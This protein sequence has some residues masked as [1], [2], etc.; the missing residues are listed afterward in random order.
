[1]H[2]IYEAT[3]IIK[4]TKL[5]NIED[6]KEEKA[7]VIKGDNKYLPGI[8]IYKGKASIHIWYNNCPHANLTLD[9]IEGKVQ[10]K[11]NDLLCANHGAKFNPETGECIKGPCKNSFL[12]IFPFKIIN[13]YLIAGN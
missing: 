6:L 8:I 2:N 7:L 3:G 11:N 9:L 13:N 5:C 4:N 12:T 10:S 1:M